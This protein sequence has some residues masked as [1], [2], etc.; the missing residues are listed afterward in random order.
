MH[1]PTAR[2]A[3]ELMDVRSVVVEKKKKQN[4]CADMADAT[5][6]WS[7]LEWR[8]VKDP[9]A[10]SFFIY[11]PGPH[12]TATNKPR[13]VHYN[14]DYCSGSFT[15]CLMSAI[16]V[17]QPYIYTNWRMRYSFSGSSAAVEQQLSSS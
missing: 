11:L 1:F 13:L 16:R 10:C 6:S 2:N 14:C 12:K 5:V 3:F 4:V 8:A 7:E 17:A 9:H 15:A